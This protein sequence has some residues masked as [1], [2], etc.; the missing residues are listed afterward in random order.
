VQ[1]RRPLSRTY[2]L[3]LPHEIEQREPGDEVD[4]GERSPGGSEAAVFSEREGVETDAKSED[5][6]EQVDDGRHLGRLRLVAVCAVGI[7]ERGAGLDADAGHHHA[8]RE[9]DPGRLVLDAHPVNDQADGQKEAE[10]GKLQSNLRLAVSVVA[11]GVAV[12]EL[13]ADPTCARL[14]NQAADSQRHTEQQAGLGGVEMVKLFGDARGGQDE[15]D[16]S[17]CVCS[18]RGKGQLT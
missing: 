5:L 17:V 15:Y 1:I 13:I 7:G 11:S 3:S 18:G 4:G 8:D 12:D 16:A 14:A 10:E 9:S 6:A 2:L